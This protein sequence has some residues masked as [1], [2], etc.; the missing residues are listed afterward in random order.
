MPFEFI[1]PSP[2]SQQK[3][4][5]GEPRAHAEEV[6]LFGPT[7]ATTRHDP[8]PEGIELFEPEE[9]AGKTAETPEESGLF[10]PME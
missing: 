10:G 3:S 8:A 1:P 4:T 9:I 7:E 2:R 6:V 5:D